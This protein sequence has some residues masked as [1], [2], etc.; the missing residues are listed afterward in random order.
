MKQPF[1]VIDPYNIDHLQNLRHFEIENDLSDSIT[2][3][4]FDIPKTC[5]KETF[6]KRVR[7]FNELNQDL[8]FC[9]NNGNI[10]DHCSLK[11]ERD[12]RACYLSFTRLKGFKGE[13]KLISLSSAYALDMLGAKEIFCSVESTDKKLLSALDKNNFTPLCEENGT[14]YLI[15]ERENSK[16]TRMSL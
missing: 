9:D 13:R 2:L 15:A 16:V 5:S 6:Q 1:L 7:E 14:T 10:I 3:S 11:F 4:L 8:C 12:I